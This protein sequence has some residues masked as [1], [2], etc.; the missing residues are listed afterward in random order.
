M[1]MKDFNAENLFGEINS[2]LK[3]VYL[4]MADIVFVVKSIT[5]RVFSISLIFYRYF[6]DIL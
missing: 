1:C 6:T 3:C 2:I 4:I 5:L